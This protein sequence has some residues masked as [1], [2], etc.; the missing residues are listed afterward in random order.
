MERYASVL[1]NGEWVITAPLLPRRGLP[2]KGLIAAVWEQRGRAVNGSLVAYRHLRSIGRSID[3]PSKT[4]SL[5]DAVNRALTDER[6][7][8]MLHP[9]RRYRTC[10]GRS[11]A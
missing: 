9:A 8:P 10:D 7:L 5:C 3:R 11:D 2:G 1:C 4:G 6:T